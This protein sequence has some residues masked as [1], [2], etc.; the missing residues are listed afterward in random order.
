[1]LAHRDLDRS[2]DPVA[3]AGVAAVPAQSM[4]DIA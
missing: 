2:A 4:K 3:T 1:V